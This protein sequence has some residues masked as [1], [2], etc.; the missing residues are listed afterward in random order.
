M[1]EQN[2]VRNPY[3]HL[4]KCLFKVS[5][6]Y[7]FNYVFLANICLQGSRE[8]LLNLYKR[9]I[10]ART[11]QQQ[12]LM[13]SHLPLPSIVIPT[14]K[15]SEVYDY[16]KMIIRKSLPLSIVEDDDY[17]VAFKHTSKFSKKLI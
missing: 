10:S 2:S 4:A 14:Q 15:D 16:V 8:A 13:A 1:Y 11:Q 3:S 9:T 6:D 5:F 17:R 7:K 12:I